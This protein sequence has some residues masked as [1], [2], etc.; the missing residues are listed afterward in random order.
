LYLHVGLGKLLFNE[1]DLDGSERA[2]EAGLQFD[3]LALSVGAID[4]WLALW[5]TKIARGERVAARA[6]LEKLEQTTRGRDEKVAHLVIVTAALQDL[7]ESKVESATRRLETLGLTANVD[8]VLE[9]VSD[10]ELSTWRHNE[11]YTYARLLIAQQKFEASL[12]VL[13]RLENAAQ[14]V[15]M[16]FL[17]SR[18]QVI[19]AVVHF[20]SGNVNRAMQVMEP[21]LERTARMKSNAVRIYLAA[22]EP[23]RSLLQETAR[24]G[25]QTE[26]VTALLAAFP[27]QVQ[28]EPIPDSPEV[29]TEREMD[30]LRLM[31]DGLKNQEIGA[32]L[33]ISLNTIRYHTT[34]I[35][36]KLSVD[37]RTAAVARARELGIF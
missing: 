37:N 21:L 15:H 36:S 13:K 18:A 35:F 9:R 26:Y 6:I 14:A 23:G 20:E 34:N 12:K 31:A 1:N 17:V 27:P 19:Q 25:I 2:L 28:P 8:D 7:Q 30:V 3:P 16:D 22:G 10:S 32:K 4:G 29:L 24:R 33:F 11:F 5:R